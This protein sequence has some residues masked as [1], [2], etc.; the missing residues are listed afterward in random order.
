VLV[1]Y[2]CDFCS[3]WPAVI[4]YEYNVTLWYCVADSGASTGCSWYVLKGKC[5]RT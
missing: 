2:G 5:G 4:C 3:D 1:N